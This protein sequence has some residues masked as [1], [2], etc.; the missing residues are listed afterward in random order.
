MIK[1]LKNYKLEDVLSRK[2]D[3]YSEYEPTVRAI[4]AD[5]AARGDEA[6][7]FYAEKFD[8]AKLDGLEVTAEEFEEAENSL[9]EE[10]K[11]VIRQSAV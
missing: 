3:D 11:A 7:R 8:G 9:S 2:I 1:I 6:L 10:L 5:V 4:I